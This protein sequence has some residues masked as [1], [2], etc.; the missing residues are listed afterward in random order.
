MLVSDFDYSLPEELIAQTP[1]EP[2]DE[3]RLM[4]L[5]RQSGEIEH[6]IFKDIAEYLRPGDLLVANESR[7][8][9]SR[10]L[11]RKVPTG[12][13]AEVLL[14]RQHGPIT[15]S[16]TALWE[17]LVKPGK[18]LKPGAAVEF[19]ERDS[20]GRE[21]P[22]GEAVLRAEVREWVEGGAPG[23]RVVELTALKGSLDEAIHAAGKLPLP[24]Y[25]HGYEGDSEMY[26]TV[27]S[28]QES[29]SAAPTA[30]L[31]FTHAL[32]ERLFAM[33]VGFATVELEIGLDTFRIPTVE[34]AE[35]HRMHSE[36]IHISQE[37]ID[38]I[39]RTKRDGGRVIAVGTTS[40]RTLESAWS[41]EEGRLVPL[42]GASTSLFILPG[43]EFHVADGLV[44]NFHVP[45]STL[46]MLV[47]AFAGRESI[48]DAYEQAVANRYRMLSFGD[49]MLII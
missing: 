33:G 25:I 16:Q 37:T 46:M 44:T 4:V 48:L 42:D 2:R 10:L 7:V 13:N 27:Y 40:M 43:Y 38:R 3:C 47:S 20:H 11:G 31:H 9:A 30:G 45:K 29:S 1:M 26:Q 12:G 8:L 5:G 35:E 41:A 15:S 39:E 14:L 32:L 24:P 36:R 34:I 18:R 22:D 23:E 6:R 28:R 17:A 19:V 49:A 21:L